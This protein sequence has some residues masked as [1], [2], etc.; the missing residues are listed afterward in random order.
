[1]FD[2]RETEL[3]RREIAPL[4]PPKV[5]MG[6]L[7]RHEISDGV[8]RLRLPTR[9]DVDR[10]AHYGS[11]P[12]LLEGIW[13]PGPRPGQDLYEWASAFVQE[14]RAGWTKVGGM[15][16]G[17]LIV[18]EREPFLGIVYLKPT[19][20]VA[21]ELS[22]GVAPHARGRG[23]AARATR[24]AAEWALTE[25]GFERVELRIDK[26]HH[27]SQRV[28]EKAGFRFVERFLTYIEG[29]GKTAED[30]LYVHTRSDATEGAAP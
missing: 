21:A 20:A 19:S 7:P 5:S 1:M 28:A 24:L 12:M 9:A 17:G 30:L 6:R 25:D 3:M 26:E 22:Y 23:I 15:Y 8:V 14:L 2:G 4:H 10:A 16:G 18:D 27:E 13:I 11:D 29:T